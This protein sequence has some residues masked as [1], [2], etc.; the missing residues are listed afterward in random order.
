MG[1]GKKCTIL[2][3]VLAVLA[4]GAVAYLVLR[5]ADP[6]E[7]IYQGKPLRAWLDDYVLLSHGWDE[8]DIEKKNEKVDEVIRQIGTNAIPT[9]FRML[10]ATDSPLKKLKYLAR[11]HG[12]YDI[13]ASDYPSALVL[14]VQAGMALQALGR[15]NPYDVVP[16]LITIYDHRPPGG[17]Q[18]I[19]ASILG[20]I[21]PAASNAVP[22]LLRTVANGG[23]SGSSIRALGEIHAE[24]K[25]VVP[26]LIQLLK[27]PEDQIRKESVVALQAFGADARPAVPALLELLTDDSDYVKKHAAQALKVI[28]PAAATKAGVQ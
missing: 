2:L 5:P 11:D 15:A 24:P 7:P 25:K 10:N 12:L 23:R 1:T 9:L 4:A 27:D 28:D 21:G 14:K 26:I 17:D 20:G 13:K 16:W 18:E 22:S 8:A 19:V 6:Q 3:G